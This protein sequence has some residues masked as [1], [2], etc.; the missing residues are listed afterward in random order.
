E[1]RRRAEEEQARREAAEAEA[2]RMELEVEERKR[3]AEEERLALEEE[4]R[5]L[6]EGRITRQAAAKAAPAPAG[7]V[8]KPAA[9]KDPGA[10]GNKSKLPL[11][12]GIAAAVIAV[13]VI[14]AVVL[15]G[16]GGSGSSAAVAEM[17]TTQLN[18]EFNTEYVSKEEG[19]DLKFMYPAGMYT[20]VT[21]E[22]GD[23]EVT[24]HFG[25]Q[26]I[27]MIDTDIILTDYKW[28]DSDTI[29]M[30]HDQAACPPNKLQKGFQD[31]I[32]AK[33]KELIPDAAIADEISTDV[34]ADDATRYSYKCTFTSAEK[35][36]GAVSA[37]IAVNSKGECKRAIVCCRDTSED[38]E[39]CKKLCDTFTEKYAGESLM[40]P[41]F[42][43][44]KSTETD[45]Q[46]EVEEMHMGVLAPKDQFKK[47][48]LSDELALNYSIFMDKN[49]ASVIVN[50]IETDIDLSGDNNYTRDQI[51]GIFDEM[52][53][54]GVNSYFTDLDS[55]MLLDESYDSRDT[56]VD[57]T[58]NY[59]D[60]I[61]GISYWERYR[62]GYWTDV[63]TQKHYFY[64]LITLVP[65]KN[66]DAYQQIFDRSLDM[67]KDI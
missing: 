3:R 21:E 5:A 25:P 30:D 23:G 55:R 56:T 13:I 40:V 51:H 61:G 12:I 41:G 57:Y 9:P 29:I 1:A 34:S 19:F 63:R 58:G 33:I 7:K 2:R 52:A 44:P 14:V 42:N 60:M 26:G 67:L 45:G 66:R 4:E 38:K 37:W 20:E 59:R 65:E 47:Y 64:I 46:L 18:D 50:P 6:A 36:N 17:D 54:K 39:A 11:Y 49:G 28:P 48:T 22:K 62:I 53:A 35:G 27:G 10:A 32:T 16:K 8:K 43:P 15:G 24:I 31:R